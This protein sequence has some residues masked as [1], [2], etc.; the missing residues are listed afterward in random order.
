MTTNLD[1]ALN[2]AREN[3]S[4]GLSKMRDLRLPT[5]DDVHKQMPIGEDVLGAIAGTLIN[6]SV[7]AYHAFFIL[8]PRAVYISGNAAGFLKSANIFEEVRLELLTG[9]SIQKTIAQGWVVKLT[10]P[11]NEDKLIQLTELPSSKFMDLLNGVLKSSKDTPTG[12]S[13]P[14]REAND[15]DIP[16][17]IRKL[18]ELVSSGLLTQT[19]F[20]AKKRELLDRM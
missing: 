17:Q 14:R 13:S 2:F 18:G 16:E 12:I 8:T 3:L 11:G 7:A 6:G 15:A 9:V 20:D 5:F 1:A 19:E 10:R 4:N